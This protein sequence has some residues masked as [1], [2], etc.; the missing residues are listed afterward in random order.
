M[1]KKMEASPANVAGFRFALGGLKSRRTV[2]VATLFGVWSLGL[3][4]TLLPPS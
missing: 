4:F 2:E 1:D 3:V